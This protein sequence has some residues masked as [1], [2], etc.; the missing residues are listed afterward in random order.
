MRLIIGDRLVE[1]HIEKYIE[2]MHI[3]LIIAGGRDFT[4]Y[5]SLI[6]KMKKIETPDLII[7][8]MARGADMLGHRYAIDRG[9]PIL[10]M[11]ANWDRYGKRAGMIRNREMAVEGT[12]LLACW[13]GRSSGTKGMISMA[14]S[15]KLETHIIR[16]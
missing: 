14:N 8:G 3:R 7:C 2:T 4:R 11:P 5:G 9:I 12:A 13:N 10:E 15:H 1:D 6:T 16:Y